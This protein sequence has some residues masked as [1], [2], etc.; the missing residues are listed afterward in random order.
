MLSRKTK[1]AIKA[2]TYLAKNY[3]TKTPIRI[4]DISR[5]EKIP[6]KFLEAILLEMKKNGV[7]SSKL[8]ANGGYYLRMPPNEIFLSTIIRLTGGPIA[9]VPCVSLNFYEE[10]EECLHPE[11][12]GIK[13]VMVELR[14]ASIKIL[15]NTSIQ[16]IIDKEK[17][18]T[19]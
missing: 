2:L 9:L 5:D 7:L 6:H 19:S 3:E 16:D 12:C 15:S 14:E 10:C 13:Q 1:Y 17:P 4:N 18:A 8:G 11:I